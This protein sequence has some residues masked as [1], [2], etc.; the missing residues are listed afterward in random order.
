MTEE[1]QEI[2]RPIKQ[3]GELADTLIRLAQKLQE[4]NRYQAKYH[5]ERPENLGTLHRELTY[6]RS[7]IDIV[8]RPYCFRCWSRYLCRAPKPHTRSRMIPNTYLPIIYAAAIDKPVRKLTCSKFCRGV[9]AQGRGAHPQ[10]SVHNA[11]GDKTTHK[12]LARKP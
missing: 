6:L 10:R 9:G 4:R 8:K 1:T 7:Y 3:S 12:R 11:Q 2:E 5:E